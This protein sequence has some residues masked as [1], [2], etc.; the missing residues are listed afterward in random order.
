MRHAEHRRRADRAN[1]KGNRYAQQDQPDH[2]PAGVTGQLANVQ[3]EAS[4]IDDERNPQ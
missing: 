4:V 2:D 3:A 1:Q